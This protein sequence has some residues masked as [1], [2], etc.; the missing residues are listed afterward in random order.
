M[1]GDV[2]EGAAH[3]RHSIHAYFLPQERTDMAERRKRKKLELRRSQGEE[4]K[5]GRECAGEVVGT[6]E[7]LNK[8]LQLFPRRGP[9]E[10]REGE[11]GRV[12]G[13]GRKRQEEMR[14]GVNCLAYS[15][16]S[17]IAC[18]LPQERADGEVRDE[19]TGRIEGEG[20]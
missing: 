6:Q 16:C 12:R 4:R 11:A 17:K 1:T 14:W 2:Y 20:V 8:C 13:A 18:F 9:R 7:A 19:G 3:S 5:W 10:H 15:K